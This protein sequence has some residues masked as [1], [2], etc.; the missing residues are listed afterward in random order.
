[1]ENGKELPQDD[2]VG[3]KKKDS[4]DENENVVK[5][6]DRLEKTS[7]FDKESVSASKD[8]S[9]KGN[10]QYLPYTK[11]RIS[12][13]PLHAHADKKPPE[14]KKKSNRKWKLFDFKKKQKLPKNPYDRDEVLAGTIKTVSLVTIAL[15]V[16][17]FFAFVFLRGVIDIFALG[18][19][20]HTIEVV[21]EENCGI[22]ELA[23]IL[24]ERGVIRYK[25]LFRIWAI[26]KK[27]TDRNFEAGVYHVSP[28]MNY[29]DLIDAFVPSEYERTQIS[30]KI[31][32]G[33]SVDDVID[34]FVE[35]GIGTR[36]GFE[37]VI[38]RYPFDTEKYWFLDDTFD[39]SSGKLWRLEGYLY[40]DTY[41]YYSDATELTAITKMLNRF[42]EMFKIEYLKHCNDLGITL[43]E[44]LTLA[45][46]ITKETK[47][48]VDYKPVSSVL[49]NRLNS[50]DFGYLEVDSTLLYLIRNK[51]GAY[52]ELTEADRG[53]ATPYNTY[54][55]AGIPPSPICSPTISTIAA[56]LYPEETEY[57]Y[58]HLTITEFC[59]YAK[60][61]AD[62]DA[63]V[64]KDLAAREE[65]ALLPD[66]TV[67]NDQKKEDE[68]G[69]L[70]EP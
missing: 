4:V 43:N 11:T 2:A 5:A 46:I 65:A 58:F 33:S 13:I 45:S 52:R 67:P 3:T 1:M 47:S 55:N 8:G 48:D 14:K 69:G 40:P 36:E 23:D 51:E 42:K 27:D 37:E 7:R 39:Q 53:L 24:H 35:S 50:P 68:N 59:E 29:D 66:A 62:Y 54:R 12:T 41:F 16:S 9:S 61:K 26:L 34:I 15:I 57:Y 28:A 49:A 6:S 63:I 64:A 38:N 20:D 21:I 56:A 60:T 19:S 10:G 22:S 32:E 25:T 44:A 18:K 70:A 31:P 30:V 17:A